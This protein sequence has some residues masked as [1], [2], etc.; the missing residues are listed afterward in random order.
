MDHAQVSSQDISIL[1]LDE[2][3]FFNFGLGETDVDA[4]WVSWQDQ[5]VP[6]SQFDQAFQIDPSDPNLIGSLIA[7]VR[8][9]HTSIAVSPPRNIPSTA[10]ANTQAEQP[11]PESPTP[12]QKRKK[13]KPNPAGHKSKRQT[14][15]NYH[16]PESSCGEGFSSLRLLGDHM[17]RIHGLK[18]FKCDNCERRVT[19]YDNLESHKKTCR[20]LS[21][22]SS[23]TAA[24]AVNRS[25]KMRGQRVSVRDI[26][27]QPEPI[28]PLPRP[29]SNKSFL[30]NS[31]EG[32]AIST[33]SL[34]EISGAHSPHAPQPAKP[35]TGPNNLGQGV[36]KG[37]TEANRSPHPA[38]GVPR[39]SS[40]TGPAFEV[41]A[42]KAQLAE[43]L[44]Q[45]EE[46]KLEASHWK[47]SFFGLQRKFDVSN[48]YTH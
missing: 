33:L 8:N 46:A 4:P 39:A 22:A 17:R 19:R 41:Q 15:I 47:K 6:E 48:V 29:S 21:A 42:L 5:T 34:R 32:A 25:G 12:S 10:P 20:S 40:A 37:A 35:P 9:P 45:L 44:A 7:T 3:E 23:T 16:C 28:R 1:G 38:A 18:G 36:P 14:L 43:V 31:F 2:E 30:N 13:N 27:L 11:D 26:T 24:P